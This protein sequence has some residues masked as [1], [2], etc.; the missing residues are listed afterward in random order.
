M[1]DSG[2]LHEMPENGKDNYYI[3]NIY[4]KSQK[5]QTFCKHSMDPI[6]HVYSEIFNP[7]IENQTMKPAQTL[8]MPPLQKGSDDKH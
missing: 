1:S 7:H 3:L 2:S 4:R 5:Q 8:R 6:L